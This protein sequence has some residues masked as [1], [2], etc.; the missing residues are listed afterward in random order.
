MLAQYQHEKTWRI[1]HGETKKS[2]M[3][4]QQNRVA[5]SAAA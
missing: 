4:Y 2:G 3:A 5:S 1:K